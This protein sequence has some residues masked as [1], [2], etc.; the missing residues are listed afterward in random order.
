MVA[1]FTGAGTGFERGSGNVLGGAGTLGQAALGRSG[2]QLLLNAA[3]GNLMLMQQ[4]ELLLGRGPDA[5]ISRTYN[6]QGDLSDE[7]GDNWRQSTDRSLYGLTGT[8]NTF[9]ST[10]K[11]ASAD[12]SVFTYV[13]N[14]TAYRTTDGAGAHDTIT[15]STADGWKWTDGD[16]QVVE[17]YGYNY[18]NHSYI[19]EQ[20]DP[21]GNALTF[22]Y[23]DGKLTD[24]RTA[25]GE[26]IQYGYSGNAITDIRTFTM[27]GGVERMQTRTRY[28]YDSLGR[29]GN[30]TVDLTPADNSVADGKSYGSAY[31]YIGDTRLI[32]SVA[33][34]D[35]T[36]VDFEYDKYRRVTAVTQTVD[37]SATRVTRLSYNADNTTIIDPA[38]QMTRLDFAGGDF[39][40]AGGTWDSGNLTRQAD[41]I[42]GAAATRYTVQ[43]GGQWAG[44]SQGFP[45]TAG[46]TM[47]FGISLKAVGD[48]TTQNLGL[49]SDQTG[50]G[51]PGI[52][53]AR[54][55]SGPGTIEHIN[56]GF[57]RVVGLSPTEGTR[58]EITRTYDKT[59]SGGAYFYVDEGSNYR[60]GTS[61]IAGGQTLVRSTDASSLDRMNATK[62]TAS[63]L[64]RAT[65]PA[66][67]GAAAYKFTVKTA[68]T[69]ANLQRTFTAKA[70]ETYSF[71]ITLK[72][73][74]F[75]QGHHLGLG[76]STSAW[77]PDD[78]SSARVLSGP[79]AV[80]PLSGGFYSVRG[81]SATEATTILV[82]RTYARDD[83]AYARL[84]VA[85]GADEPAGAGVIVA[86]VN[87]IGPVDEP[88]TS[89]LLTKIT[90]PATE[91]GAAQQVTQFS[92]TSTGN[93]A[94]VTDPSGGITRMT[95]D[96][97][98]NLLT[99]TDRLGNVVTR[100]YDAKNQ[101]LRTSASAV[102]AG[103]AETVASNNVYDSANRLRYTVSAER[104]VTRY[105]Y[106][107]NGLLIRTD[108]FT[109]DIPSTSVAMT[110]A[111]LN[112]WVSGLSA[113]SA[114]MIVRYEYDARGEVSRIVR[115]G[116]ADASG[117]P[118]TTQGY[119]ET[120]FVR[121][122][123]GRLLERVTGGQR[124][125]F[126]YDGLG[127]MIGSTDVRGGQTSIAF[128]DAGAQ[129]VVTLAS[130]AVQTST[131]NRAGDLVSA[132]EAGSYSG[133]GTT[134]YRYDRTGRVRI[135][136]DSFGQNRYVVYDRTGRK[137]GEV[138]PLGQLTEY[139]YDQN[140]R[141]VA[142]IGWSTALSAEQM[143]RLADPAVDIDV[144]TIRPAAGAAD[145]WN[146][147]VYD[148]E[149]RVLQ[150]IDATG[151][152]VVYDYDASGRLLRET[153]YANRVAVDALKTTLPTA[154]T[155]P[156][157][158]A[159]RDSVSRTFYDRDGNV[160][161]ALDGEGYLSRSTYDA[162]GNRVSATSFAKRVTDTLRT[163]ASFTA[164]LS[165]VG[166]N[167]NDRTVRYVYDGQ[168]LLRF[169]VDTVQRVTEYVY[170]GARAGD[171]T[172][173]VRQTI[174]Y[175]RPI[176]P[177][178]SYSMATVVQG[179]ATVGATDDP[180]NRRS[181]AVY[182]DRGNL[183]FAID[184]A[185]SVTGYGY[186][187][188]GN[189]VK[190]TRFVASYATTTLPAHETMAAWATANGGHG[191]T[192]V[193]RSY[194]AARGEL[195]F[196][197]DPMGYVSRYDYDA[198]GRV[199][200][201]VRFDTAMA[202]ATDAT[203]I[204][205]VAAWQT[206]TS[207]VTTTSYDAAGRVFETTDAAGTVTRYTY[208]V[209]GTVQST[210]EAYGTVDQVRTQLG[211]D[212]AG[213]V[214]TRIADADG[215]QST[216]RYTYDGFGNLLTQVAPDGTST[217]SFT[218]DREGRMLTRTNALGQVQSYDY[219]S[220]GQRVRIVDERGG[221]TYS[222]YDA[223]GRVV[224]V[225]DAEN[226]VTETSYT[227]FDQ[228][229]T[230][231][232]RKQRA[233]NAA[234][235]GTLPTV[236]ADAKD[237]VTQFV[238]DKVGR[239]VRTIDAEGFSEN[240]RYNSFGEVVQ[241]T[242][243]LGG[244]TFRFYDRRGQVFAENVAKTASDAS[245]FARAKTSK[246]SEFDPFYYANTYDDLAG[247]ANDPIAL[248]AHWQNS[249][250]REGRNPN[251]DFDT[252][253]YL[254]SN[255]DVAAAGINPLEHY[256]NY[257]AGEGRA[258][259]T[260]LVA[261]AQEA[262]GVV[263]HYEY[264]ARGNRTRMIE[265]W[266]LTEQR[267]TDYSY[268]ALDRLIEKRG[269]AVDYGVPGSSA[270]AGT[271]Q[272]TEKYLYDRHGN[273]T[274]RTDAQGRHSWFYYD[275]LDRK[276]GE[277]DAAGA[278]VT[279][280]YDK[281]GGLIRS[282]A[283]ATAVTT[284]QLTTETR[285]AATGDYRET[286]YA[287]DVL[288]RRLS[289]SM[290]NI[291]TGAWDAAIGT[292]VYGFGTVTQSVTYDAAGNAVRST[293][294]TGASIL[295]YYDALGRKTAQVDQE[296]FLTE[297]TLDA[298]G[299]ALA[300][301]RYAVAVTDATEA[302]R[303][304]GTVNADDR[305]TEFS[306][307]RNGRRLTET[308]KDVA[309]WSVD[310]T[311]GAL[312]DVSGDARITYSYNGLGLVTSKREATGDT[313]L[314][315]YDRIGRLIGEQRPNLIN[316][317]TDEAIPQVTYYYDG[318][319]NLVRTVEGVVGS[320]DRVTT[321]RYDA[322]GRKVAMT[323]A[324]GSTRFYFYDRV[325]NMV[326][327]A[328]SR[329][330]SA[331]SVLREGAI[332]RYDN[333]GRLRGQISATNWTQSS[334]GF[335]SL[336]TAGAPPETTF[337]YNV[338]G[339]LVSRSI[340]NSVQEQHEYDDA[341]RAWRSTGGDG[342]WRYFLYDGAGRQTLTLASDG[343]ANIQNL[344]LGN[345]LRISTLDGRALGDPAN[346]IVATATQYDARG[347]V[348]RVHSLQRELASGVTGGTDLRTSRS[349]TAF[350]EVASETDARDATTYYGYNRMGRVTSIARPVVLGADIDG[351]GIFEYRYYDLSGR[352]AG[353]KDGNGNLATRRLAGGTGYGG[354]A[355][356]VT[357]EYHAD[358]GRV[359]QRYDDAGNL[360][361]R[362]D[363]LGR[364][365]YMSYDKLGRLLNTSNVDSRDI[366]HSY[367]YDS[368]GRR[369]THSQTGRA[370][371][372]RETTDYDVA[373][374]VTTSRAFGGEVTT[375]AYAWDSAINSGLGVT[376]GWRQTTTFSNS[377][378]T[379]ESKDTFGRL[380]SRTDMGGNVATTSYD[381]AG[382]VATIIGLETQT[383]AWLNTG[384]LATQTS[385]MGSGTVRSVA[386]FGYDQV[387]NRLTETFT[388][389][390]VVYR[391]SEAIFDMQNRMRSWADT[392]DALPAASMG[393]AY[394][395]N[396]NILQTIATRATLNQ[397][398]GVASTKTEERWFRYD[399]MNRVTLDGG[400]MGASGIERGSGTEITYRVDGSR[401]M[402]LTSFT[403]YAFVRD[404]NY[405]GGNDPR[406]IRAAALPGGDR[407]IR[408]AYA[409]E[410][411]ETYSWRNDGQVSTVLSEQ[412]GYYENEDGTVTPD[413]IFTTVGAAGYEYDVL[414]R[415]T[416][417]TDRRGGNEA[418][419]DR[420]VT[421]DGSGRG[422]IVAETTVTKQGTDTINT[423][424]STDYGTGTDYALGAVKKVT[425]TTTVN[426]GSSTTTTTTNSYEWRDAAQL[427]G[428][429][430]T[431]TNANTAYTSYTYSGVG[432]LDMVSIG[433]DRART[434][435][436]VND[437]AGQVIKRDEADS[438]ATTGDP[439]EIWY[440][441]GGREMGYVGNNG[442]ASDSYFESIGRRATKPSE[443]STFSPL[444]G[445]SHGS[446]FAET[447]DRINSYETGSAG[448]S[449]TVQAGD[450]L[451]GIA[452][453]VWGD[454][455]LWYKLA[456]ANGLGA[457]SALVAGQVLT[458]PAGVVRST[459][460][461]D[462][463]R[464]YDPT[465]V[466]GDL[467]PNPK[468]KSNKCGGFGRILLAAVAIAV[469]AVATA[470]IGALATGASFAGSFGALGTGSLATFA[471]SSGT[472]LGLTG[473]IAAGVAG[474]MAGSAASQGLAI[475]IG[476][477]D[478]FSWGG[479]AM[480]G[481]SAAVGGSLGA[482][483][484]G[485]GV[486][487][488]A[489]R[490]VVGNAVMQGVAIATK[491]Q[492]RFDWAGL[493]AAGVTAG[494]GQAVAGSSTAAWRQELAGYASGVAGA[495]TR[496]ILTGTSFGDNI[497]A[498]L[499]DV[500]GATIGRLV[501]RGIADAVSPRLPIDMGPLLANDNVTGGGPSSPAQPQNLTTAMSQA[502]AIPVGVNATAINITNGKPGTTP[503]G[504][505][506]GEYLP[507]YQGGPTSG[508]A[509]GV[510]EYVNYFEPYFQKDAAGRMQFG[511]YEGL[512]NQDPVWY[513][514]G[515]PA[516]YNTLL[517]ENAITTLVS[518]IVNLGTDVVG[519]LKD[520]VM[521][522]VAAGLYVSDLLRGGQ[523]GADRLAQ[524]VRFK[525]AVTNDPMLLVRGALEPLR[526]MFDEGSVRGITTYVAGA[527]VTGSVG[528]IAS[529]GKSL[530]R[531][532]AAESAGTRGL[533]FSPYATSGDL[534]QSIATRADN[535][536]IRNGLGNG[537][538]AGTAKHGYAEDVLNRYQRMFGDRGLTAEAR[539]VGGSPWMSGMSTSGSI[540]LD[541]VEGP[542]ARPTGVWD[543]KFGNATLSRGRIT[544][545]QNGIP[546]GANVPILMVKP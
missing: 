26:R 460:N 457:D 421:Y 237:A 51:G 354:A 52:S 540:R 112:S 18:R 181:F 277:V 213:R 207:V 171:A 524:T 353:A 155:R 41:T 385:D 296:G 350:G 288:G 16:S 46:E 334:A 185:G 477:Q 236:A 205:S 199:V 447:I 93:V 113:K 268:D 449:Y 141:L 201:V 267:T 262:G 292:Y 508:K 166:T 80:D 256:A 388:R 186:D 355:E 220:F 206:G 8:V 479:V 313:T 533:G 326:A 507:T 14:G 370:T 88:E 304:Q 505:V 401:A 311:T 465:D 535:W 373:G 328:Y 495:A 23:A 472:A 393:W 65:E 418:V 429:V 487:G 466:L 259:N 168:G 160:I 459:Y 374:R 358:G 523:A 342:T 245:G 83:S 275:A 402:A 103:A 25:N 174:A 468:A 44:I 233:G 451:S 117:E 452:D 461:A 121:D 323:D 537:P 200:A 493:A 66:I 391:R 269:M 218:Y 104:R 38:G 471:A 480:A 135:A 380:T 108:S 543:Y 534:V 513:D 116:A 348:T 428:T 356:L 294:A 444:G 188:S 422:Q 102:S 365:T 34:T 91:A 463:Y 214:V 110:E 375:N 232:R 302:S 289:S 491:Q 426:G 325:G 161:G 319:D 486:G 420:I 153:G 336:T 106:N 219:D 369:L 7:N 253:Y 290:A 483:P 494:I 203:T 114:R 119:T 511:R 143:A 54:I 12:G 144:A 229:A 31:T 170:A 417:Q 132:S 414:G 190:T 244:V 194:Y 109:A 107:A 501:T 241:A 510:V 384:L 347:Q 387:G 193:T 332:Y 55:V 137:T 442:S 317:T 156:T 286:T 258:P 481:L 75:D 435:T 530:G 158:D 1:I 335:T 261:G 458:I 19:S 222:Y 182:D 303:P 145:R 337:S 299:N 407:I 48:I 364:A 240:S 39:A 81:L 427:I 324:M 527:A 273:L 462:T 77:G 440:R 295:S 478:K 111:A 105:T 62:W 379:I 263:T 413:E 192:R 464:P 310:P 340:G 389:D 24:L 316:S 228:I 69:A 436:F 73:T 122:A 204:A 15:Y 522:P 298:E 89:R 128:N 4:D 363:E 125:L 95:Y 431:K 50:W 235:I 542:L 209:N 538:A 142:T 195:R 127:R 187:G 526:Q 515:S 346:G 179:L 539:Y 252:R 248:R 169:T 242:N 454:A 312:T 2:E 485:S 22:A 333:V 309:A 177:L 246:I 126:V 136:T 438:N 528:A 173:K 191:D 151:A 216:T 172:G 305:V 164:L 392:S 63:N 307:D 130:G 97:A 518:G 96:T 120:V 60:A 189:V 410:R 287:N 90:A 47:T 341:G 475:G 138:D 154:V 434:V 521:T 78:L 415:L 344:S 184:A 386:T 58:V 224:M 367:T 56:G 297:W 306:Y 68:S 198:G 467:N 368:L 396:G 376:G 366:A 432:Q 291:R 500:I 544:Q 405:G 439:H 338:F 496:S 424:T 180:A 300:E 499:P 212:A 343:S 502:A 532:S 293:D 239:V 163:S 217:T 146:W 453:Q 349:Y 17:T 503:T 517:R 215:L 87:L 437:L 470:G 21:S 123:S 30:A 202:G 406:A 322:V 147:V 476:L 257:G 243:K 35:G 473:T 70:G 140:D 71:V 42:N 27:Q 152:S 208:N 32:A 279:Y 448:R 492:S 278:Y 223:A 403:G 409:A 230:V 381:Q 162:A 43:T 176:A 395:R 433:G 490:G 178:A 339:E 10:V 497:M 82:T 159:A 329:R 72:A 9:G 504:T 231:I 516:Q 282:R 331:G 131:Y 3:N 53:V 441:H 320:T 314:Y 118:L 455:S 399:A 529:S 276:N 520:L 221:T 315:T 61:L 446:D 265:A 280:A 33:Q 301:R 76:G 264:D 150:R 238:Y 255:P 167:A 382:R 404:P 100:T 509:V 274:R 124:E 40:L 308:R 546:N 531:V 321:N 270:N 430:T 74:G 210:T 394:D 115:D 92:Y 254:A 456:T 183:T 488:A 197:V 489:V 536:G 29:L 101:L 272:P 545:I 443:T 327:E 59:G 6:S 361:K 284:S 67:N 378:Q 519:G 423:R 474:A 139:R 157:A 281:N 419:Y 260:Q 285:P 5:A 165:D 133:T 227:A 249:G 196:T 390:N 234:A 45:V 250:W 149:G 411:R 372:D 36:R 525:Q 251:A 37:G 84:F 175:A 330:N 148:R 450:T 85:L 226:Y 397:F 359:F 400:R 514:Y 408:V 541:V 94:T 352:L 11:R 57:W 79:G 383:F 377:K 283:Y 20:R 416:R 247:I 512:P 98:G 134:G 445:Q 64:N 398:G 371:T 129:T 482:L 360:V 266:S 345:V 13:W 86:G 412:T 99:T 49:Y 357:A 484:L 425:A 211:Y 506:T 28:A 469:A 498:V 225:R 351:T 271:A 362:T 318:N